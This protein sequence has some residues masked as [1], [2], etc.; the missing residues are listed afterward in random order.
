MTNVSTV[1]RMIHQAD[2]GEALKTGIVL[3]MELVDSINQRLVEVEAEI[4]RMRETT[5][6][7]A[8]RPRV[9]GPSVG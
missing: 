9:G 3:A 8:S 4:K 5:N 1:Q 7:L 2:S 6:E